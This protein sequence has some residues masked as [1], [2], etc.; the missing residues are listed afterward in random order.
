MSWIRCARS[1][2][3][4]P[5]NNPNFLASGLGD[6]DGYDFKRA[7]V[8]A[9]IDIVHQVISLN[10]KNEASFPSGNSFFAALS[11]LCEFI[12]DCE[13]TIISVRILHPLGTYGPTASANPSKYIRYIYNRVILENASVRAAAVTA[14]ARFA[15]SVESLRPRILTLLTRC[16]D[17]SDDEVRDHAAFFLSVLEDERLQTQHLTNG[18]FFVAELT[19]KESVYTWAALEHNLLAYFADVLLIRNPLIFNQRPCSPRPRK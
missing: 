13:Y 7:I 11:H 3:R 18:A 6:G 1:V 16:L 5:L 2:S 19:C 17:D 9:V 4:F 10:L 15:V 8:D 14:L 12:E